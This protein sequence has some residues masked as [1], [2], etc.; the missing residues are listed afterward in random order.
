MEYQNIYNILFIIILLIIIYKISNLNS[1]NFTDLSKQDLEA[2]LNLSSMYN[3]GELKIAKLHVTDN[4]QFD[5]NITANKEITSKNLNT[6]YVKVT[7]DI[8]SDGS[9][10]SKK[11]IQ[12]KHLKSTHDSWVD[13][14]LTNGN[15]HVNDIISTKRLDIRNVDGSNGNTHFNYD[16]TGINYL[17]GKKSYFDA[18]NWMRTGLP[19]NKTY[20]SNEAAT[21]M[22]NNGGDSDY[23]VGFMRA[24]YRHGDQKYQNGFVSKGW[25]GKHQ[26]F[27]RGAQDFDWNWW[28]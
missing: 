5:K 19:D 1:E 22:K 8:I 23:Y 24:R 11:Y 13:G 4:A 3:N 18:H 15:L 14:K 10:Y 12:G 2:L 28:Q 21:Y 16:N 9:I 20:A 17:R 26:G 7:K 25:H 27:F 6:E